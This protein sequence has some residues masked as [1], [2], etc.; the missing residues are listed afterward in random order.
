MARH[1]RRPSG[2]I[3]KIYFRYLKRFP[4]EIEFETTQDRTTNSIGSRDPCTRSF[5]TRSHSV[6]RLLRD[7]SGEAGLLA[8]GRS[9][10]VD[11]VCYQPAV[12]AGRLSNAATSV[13]LASSSSP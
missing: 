6:K 13:D 10:V 7:S 9:F 4:K 12:A 3:S 8:A 5:S 1:T 11:N 2:Y